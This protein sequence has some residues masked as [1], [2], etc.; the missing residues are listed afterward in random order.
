MPRPRCESSEENVK[1]NSQ[2]RHPSGDLCNNSADLV[3]NRVNCNVFASE[4]SSFVQHNTA[5]LNERTASVTSS[6][7]SGSDTLSPSDRRSEALN[8]KDPE[9][10]SGRDR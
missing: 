5:T 8:T 2:L 3:D 6:T 4:N 1:D 10:D 9:Q 7:L